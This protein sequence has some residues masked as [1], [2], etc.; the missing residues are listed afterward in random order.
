[1]KNLICISGPDGTGK[2]TQVGLLIDSLKSKGINVEYRWLR[3]HHLFS[4]PILGLARFLGYSEVVTL[5]NGDRMGYHY[6]Y[7]SKLISLI[8]TYSMLFD[9]LI[10]SFIKLYIPIYIFRKK[11]VCDRYI[12]DT[13]VDLMISTGNHEFYDSYTGKI[14]LKLIPSDSQI[15]ILIT[16]EK[17]LKKRREDIN[18]DKNIGLKINLYEKLIENLQISTINAELPIDHVSVDI[19]RILNE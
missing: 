19:M 7:K 5:K 14:F 13:L 15:I 6:F 1:M 11:L 3:F 18:H 2:S 9:S 4:L 16:D 12:H 17:I 10:F 8:Y